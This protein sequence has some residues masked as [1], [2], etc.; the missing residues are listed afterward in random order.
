MVLNLHSFKHLH[1]VVTGTTFLYT[2]LV[3]LLFVSEESGLMLSQCCLYTFACVRVRA[4]A[5]LSMYPFVGLYVRVLPFSSQ[6][7]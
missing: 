7:S 6:N 5:G 1:V 4:H 3:C 2:F